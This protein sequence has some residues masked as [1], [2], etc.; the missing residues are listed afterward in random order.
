MI[1]QNQF[2]YN[3]I[4]YVIMLEWVL[5]LLIG[6]AFWQPSPIRDQWIWLVGLWIPFFL[7]KLITPNYTWRLT[8]LDGIIFAFVLLSWLSISIAPF[9]TRGLILIFRPLYGW[10]LFRYL[11]ESSNRQRTTQRAE[12]ATLILFAGIGI[13][14]LF[15]TNWSE[16]AGI[17]N[18][19]SDLIPRV[20]ILFLEGGFNVNEIAGALT[21]CL[22]FLLAYS[23]KRTKWSIFAIIMAILIGVSLFL[24]Q[25]LA[26]LIGVT[27]GCLLVITPRRWFQYT[28]LIALCGIFLAHTIIT[29]SPEA[30]ARTLINLS[31]RESSQSLENRAE[32]WR[33]AVDI[34]NDYPFTGAGIANYRS[35]TVRRL[36]PTPNF[37][38]SV[39]VHTHNELLQFGT[40]IGFPGMII[41][42]SMIIVPVVGLL[43]L[44][45]RRG[46]LIIRGLIGS[47]IAHSIFG[48]ADA[49]PVWDRFAFLF[50]WV[51]GLS[52]AYI[53]VHSSQV[54]T[55]SDNPITAPE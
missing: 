41:Y 46:D 27:V 40:D 34:I 42:L 48:I 21:W 39:A 38:N 47:L 52:I 3:S 54:E 14:S 8:G 25:S 28:T 53:T 26:A 5:L 20:N 19:I 51:L 2:S 29:V 17:L 15:T 12:I 1:L 55:V 16:K 31:L 36:Y 50:W 23:F 43:K 10:I 6:I 13:I 49:I 30:S 22:P 18:Q 32:L 4:K 44:H 35:P 33:S 9:Q 45:T 11:V 24:G 37:P 7:L